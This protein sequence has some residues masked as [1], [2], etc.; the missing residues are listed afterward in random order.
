MGCS[1][2]GSQ[3][4][5]ANQ[6]CPLCL[7]PTGTRTAGKQHFSADFVTSSSSK[8][9]VQCRA[10]PSSRTG[11]WS[12]NYPCSSRDELCF[13]KLLG[14]G[15]VHLRTLWAPRGAPVPKASPR[16]SWLPAAL[17]PPTSNNPELW[18][19][20]VSPLSG[21]LSDIVFEF[22]GSESP[23]AHGHGHQPGCYN[24]RKHFPRRIKRPRRRRAELHSQS[25]CKELSPSTPSRSALQLEGFNG[26]F[27]HAHAN[28]ICN[29][30]HS[31]IFTQLQQHKQRVWLVFAAVTCRKR[32]AR[33]PGLHYDQIRLIPTL[34]ELEPLLH[35][36][37]AAQP[38]P[39]LGEPGGGLGGAWAANSPP[40]QVRLCQ[41]T[42][43][44]PVSMITALLC[45]ASED[46]ALC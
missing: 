32:P 11:T 14:T 17:C 42:S 40:G 23:A 39:G 6:S 9:R 41:R 15:P 46:T 35:P 19:L 36:P 38:G 10:A 37:W 21:L 29:S 2:P 31:V 24:T 20:A 16:G 18:I 33:I 12:L 13:G 25:V 8:L 30:F 43:S 45:Q 34:C 7:H 28:H 3:S 44:A 27:S 4:A 5:E 22:P 26:R 1:K